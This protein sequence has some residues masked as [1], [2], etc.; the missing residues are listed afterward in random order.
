MATHSSVLAWRI[1][2][3]GKP[4]G[5]QSMGSQSRTRLKRLS[6]SSSSSSLISLLSKGLSR[7]FSN[8]RVQSINSLMLSLIYGPTLTTIHNYQKN[9]SFDYKGPLL[10]VMSL[11]LNMLSRF[12]IGFLPRSKCLLISWLESPSAVILDPKKIKSV[13]V[14]DVSPSIC[15]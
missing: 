1:P 13:I 2:W 6:S 11:L 8:T 14:S 9:H 4:G 10:A 5:L 3:T 7:V 12:I 15:H